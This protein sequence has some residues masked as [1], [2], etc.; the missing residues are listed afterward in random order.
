M[1][2]LHFA[3]IDNS[4]TSGV[5]V[6][7]RQHVLA[8][9]RFAKTALINVSGIELSGDLPQ[10]PYSAPFAMR[11]LPKPFDRP[12]LAVFHE[13]YRPV[14]L[15][16]AKKLEKSGVPYIILPHGELRAE[17]Q[18]KKHLKKAAA[19]FLLFNRFIDHAAAIQCLSESESDATRFGRKKIIGT[20]GVFIPETRKESF[21][22]D[23]AVFLYIGRYEWLPKGLDLLFDAIKTDERILREKNCRFMLYGPDYNGRFAAVGEMIANREIG[24]L[25]SLHHEILGDEKT[26]ALLDADV[27]IQTSRHEGMPVGILE[28]MSYGLPCLV[29]EGTSL[30]DEIKECRAGW[31]AETTAQDI[32]RALVCAVKERS[33]WAEYGGNGRKAVREKYSWDVVAAD[34]VERYRALLQNEGCIS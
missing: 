7:A 10:M 13:C 5:C 1:V 27:F 18:K 21:R 14:Y 16:I 28:A 15:P 6:S 34:T 32:A 8:Q 20:N 23:E 4:E 33:R 31:C 11:D 29:T 26:K 22:K 2:I 17:A 9:G 24:D 25:V 3:C 12:D 19:N 30:G